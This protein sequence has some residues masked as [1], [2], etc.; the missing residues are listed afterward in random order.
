MKKD[1]VL[2]LL[3]LDPKQG[4]G[5][6][7]P[8]AGTPVF[9]S[10]HT[11]PGGLSETVLVS[12]DAE[13]AR[14]IGRVNG[15][16][17]NRLFTRMQRGSI[18]TARVQGEGARGAVEIAVHVEDFG[19]AGMPIDGRAVLPSRPPR[20]TR[21]V[22]FAD[23]PLTFTEQD[24]NAWVRQ[25]AAR[26]GECENRGEDLQHFMQEQSDELRAYEAR[27]PEAARRNFRRWYPAQV[28]RLDESYAAA[29]ALMS[30]GQV[31]AGS[32]LHLVLWTVVVV[33][34]VAGLIYEAR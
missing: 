6:Q 1:F 2:R 26:I 9:L 3:P 8:P 22:G 11:G 34:I 23:A 16:D 12:L 4:G 28:E 13:G 19:N 21:A 33:L 24:V 17:P 31:Q 10:A 14:P 20:R 5:L 29:R 25:I 18:A 32:R 27:L 15:D 7:A 30:G